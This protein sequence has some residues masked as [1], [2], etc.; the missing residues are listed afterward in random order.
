MA[1]S[2]NEKFFFSALPSSFLF[3]SPPLSVPRF[4][5]S[6]FFP[7]RNK[8]I[9]AYPF[10]NHHLQHQPTTAAMQPSAIFGP[11][12]WLSLAETPYLGGFGCLP[13]SDLSTGVIF[14][15]TVSMAHQHLDTVS[16][17]TSDEED[18]PFKTSP[19]IVVHIPCLMEGDNLSACESRPWHH[20]APGPERGQGRRL[21][22]VQRLH[23]AHDP[24]TAHTGGRHPLVAAA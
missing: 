18:H 1:N 22:Q 12:G 24:P 8:P 14:R 2:F 19:L 23:H 20:E 4:H 16:H 21:Q 5:P 7:L 17:L 11:L 6:P 15:E 3:L 13:S 10:K 9:I